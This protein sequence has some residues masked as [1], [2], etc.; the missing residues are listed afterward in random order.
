MSHLDIRLFSFI[1]AALCLEKAKGCL[2]STLTTASS[3][4]S[5][6]CNGVSSYAVSLDLIIALHGRITANE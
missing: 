1:Q 4:I 6:I 5:W 3:L 2:Q